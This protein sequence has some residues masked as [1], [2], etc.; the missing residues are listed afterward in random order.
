ML[1][2]IWALP[3]GILL[4]LN[5]RSWWVVEGEMSP[6]QQHLALLWGGLNLCNLL[7]ALAT[8]AI[9]KWKRATSNWLIGT[10]QLILQCGFLWF[11]TIQASEVLPA[12]VT[13]WI[14][15]PEHVVFNHWTWVMPSA[16]F[17]VVL[18][19]G[20]PLRYSLRSE[21]GL[22]ILAVVAG[23]VLFYAVINLS[24]FFSIAAPVALVTAL[25]IL[26]TTISSLLLGLGLVRL[27]LIRL[28]CLLKRKARAMNVLVVLFALV[29]PLGGL[30]L[31]RS[32]PFPADYQSIWVYVLTVLNAIVLS[33]PASR[34]PWVNAA[35]LLLRS[36]L[37]PF[38]LYFFLVF[39]PYLPLAIPA[40]IAVATGFLILA[41]T[42]LFIVHVLRLRDVWTGEL[43]FGRA[44][45]FGLSLLAFAV[46][47]GFITL[48]SLYLGHQLRN[49]L[50]WVYAPDA[51]SQ[52]AFD[53][54]P[55]AVT[56]AC[57]WLHDYKS[58]RFLPYLT[59]Y[60]EWLMFD[61]FVLPDDK[62]T[63]VYE[64]F[65]G[66][67]LDFD[68]TNLRSS[69]GFFSMQRSNRDRNRN[70]SR[71]RLLRAAS[72]PARHVNLEMLSSSVSVDADAITRST[73]KLDLKAEDTHAQLEYQCN[74]TLPAG[75]VVSGF[76]LHIG[77]ERVPGRIFEKKT[78]L[79]VYQMIR[80]S[81]R[82][83]GLLYYT[84]PHE[85]TLHVFPFN[86][87]ETRTVE[88]ELMYPEGLVRTVEIDGITAQLGNI[89][90]VAVSSSNA[91]SVVLNKPALDGLPLIQRKPYWH[92][93]IDHSTQALPPETTLEC[94]QSVLESHP[95]V[96]EMRAT[97]VNFESGQSY[98]NLDDLKRALMENK[99]TARGGF[100]PDRA[101]MQ[102]LTAYANET[103][104][105]DADYDTYP[106]FVIISDQSIKP[107]E[108]DLSP[109]AGWVPETPGVA[110]TGPG[111][112]SGI[113]WQ[114]N[115]MEALAPTPV[116]PVSMLAKGDS[117]R[118]LPGGAWSAV[119]TF[120]PESR[121]QEL[122]FLESEGRTFVPLDQLTEL[123]LENP[124]IK[125]TNLQSA[126]LAAEQNPARLTG[127]LPEL[128]STS[129]AQGIL[130]PQTSYIVVENSAQWRML[131][132]TEKEK[133][134]ANPN[135]EL[136]ETPEPAIWLLG[137]SLFAFEAVRRRIIAS[138][139]TK[140]PE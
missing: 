36:L 31:N 40:I 82:D 13:T 77:D 12:S 89:E 66:K 91:D 51:T 3:M 115:P 79:W 28:S 132:K 60:R 127:A 4:L 30:L 25:A 38:T 5:Y 33:V 68:E 136:V 37:F 114:G 110:V 45:A 88:L 24:M 35:L 130:I 98:D 87:G 128:V 94:I 7:A 57:L 124:Y 8:Y 107:W 80:D 83:P 74:F 75:A 116:L 46:L 139:R 118:P 137:I 81:R 43:P 131:E 21:T 62:L 23:P 123:S 72:P 55:E 93:I 92:F 15:P 29:L 19:A 105:T 78:A 2:W 53:G 138:S 14:L 135:L 104:R 10:I 1:L 95:S 47:P 99:L 59:P 126:S 86:S 49:G 52:A 90:H 32:I 64:A 129:K 58:D 20:F 54:N 16:F 120:T 34:S 50:N 84:G 121:G 134:D 6:E 117:V 41:P 70:R 102:A 65:S 42:V 97:L 73:L 112:A 106:V 111:E 100:L 44:T 48:Q 76:W 125:A 26:L 27:L 39:L 122:R 113:D 9:L 18:L 69:F 11:A 85:L 140:Q 56:E 103:L 17:G 109:L 108:L 61:G 119:A 71:N 63:H 133:L 22:S 67:P 101:I 96:T